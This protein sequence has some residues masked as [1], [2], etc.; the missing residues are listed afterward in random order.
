MECVSLINSLRYSFLQLDQW[1]FWGYA[2]YILVKAE[3]NSALTIS[4]HEY[5]MT[6]NPISTVK[7]NNFT[8]LILFG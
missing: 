1:P 4:I 7:L 6:F 5:S 2:N 3:N 8:I